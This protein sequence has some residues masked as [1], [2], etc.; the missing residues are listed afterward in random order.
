MSAYGRGVDVPSIDASLGVAPRWQ[1]SASV[2]YSRIADDA[3]GTWHGFGDLYVTTKVRLNKPSA[4]WG[5]AVS[6]TLELLNE[7]TALALGTRRTH[8]VL[9]VSAEVG[10]APWRV[11]GTGGYF[12]RGAVFAS[13]AVERL[14]GD[15]AAVT[16]IIMHA[17]S[18]A[19][20][21][22]VATPSASRTDGACIVAFSVTPGVALFGSIG[23]T[24]TGLEPDGSRLLLGFGVSMQLAA[25]QA[26]P[27]DPPRPRSQP[28]KPTRKP[29]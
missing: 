22:A 16:G 9:P 7:D 19:D 10:R 25:P 29:R 5:V 24:L 1:L 14:I 28:D 3:G 11:Y 6:P 27:A 23:R 4:T 20:D 26:P 8:L 13:G 21:A 17:R 18:T 2:P 15:R 12:T